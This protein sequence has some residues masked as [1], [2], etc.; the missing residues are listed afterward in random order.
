MTWWYVPA[1]CN[2]VNRAAPVAILAGAIRA[3]DLRW[4]T[5]SYEDGAANAQARQALE[6]EADSYDPIEPREASTHVC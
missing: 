5:F 3:L 6:A 1:D 2:H 4:P